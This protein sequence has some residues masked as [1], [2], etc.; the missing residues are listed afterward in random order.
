MTDQIIVAQAEIK[1]INEAN[2]LMDILINENLSEYQK[3]EKKDWIEIKEA[4]YH[5]NN[6]REVLNKI[7]KL[8]ESKFN[9]SKLIVKEKESIIDYG[10][11]LYGLLDKMDDIFSVAELKKDYRPISHSQILVENTVNRGNII[12]KCIS[13][14]ALQPFG[15]KKEKNHFEYLNNSNELCFENEIKIVVDNIFLKKV[16][17]ICNYLDLNNL[18]KYKEEEWFFPISI[19]LNLHDLNTTDVGFESDSFEFKLSLLNNEIYREYSEFILNCPF[20]LRLLI[21]FILSYN[22]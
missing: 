1:N 22:R 6:R 10:K 12:I 3:Q 17:F 18:D 7:I 9:S 20:R 8:N 16:D 4:I 13:K 5:N 11:K 2:E 19:N 15:F 14:P 21:D